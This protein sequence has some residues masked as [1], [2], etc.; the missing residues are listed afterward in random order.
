MLLNYQ[1]SSENDRRVRSFQNDSGSKKVYAEIRS[2]VIIVKPD[3]ERLVSFS[4]CKN[5]ACV[6]MLE[7]AV[8]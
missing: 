7:K 5:I 6:Y 1:N 2:H 8:D 4:G 3:I